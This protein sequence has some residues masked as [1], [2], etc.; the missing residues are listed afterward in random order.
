MTTKK[1]C[2]VYW[3][4]LEHHTDISS[5][6][7]I[8]ITT[9]GV[10]ERYVRHKSA[11]YSRKRKSRINHCIRKYG[12]AIKVRTLLEGSVEYC[13]LV[14]AT[15]RPRELIGWNLAIGGAATR[16]GAKNSPEHIRKAADANRGI[17]R[18][19]EQVESNRQNGLRQ[20][21][22]EHPWQHPY[23]N[24]S[25]WADASRVYEWYKLHPRD[26]RRTIGKALN[27]LPDSIMHLLIKIKKGWIP[28]KDAVYMSWL[29]EY[30]QIKES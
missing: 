16:A 28:F 23:T 9:L 18:T 15:L 10:S 17:K 3:L 25:A 12:D 21:T 30:N 20:M 14:E 11:A 27:M 19:A 7:Y 1:R 2:W 13:Q 8:G 6:G 29:S 5:E 4:H 24:K 22:F 26:G